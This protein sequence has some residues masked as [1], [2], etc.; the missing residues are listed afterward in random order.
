MS[1][2]APANCRMLEKLYAFDAAYRS[3]NEFGL[4]SVFFR[5][6]DAEESR[7]Y[8]Y[9][10]APL[11]AVVFAETGGDG[12]HFS[13]LKLNGRV[14]EESPVLFTHPP[15]YWDANGVRAANLLQLLTM[16]SYFGFEDFWP[17]K[18]ENK[19]K[20]WWF[21]ESMDDQQRDLLS[22][23]RTHF[24]LLPLDSA[25]IEAMSLGELNRTILSQLQIREGLECPEELREWWYG[26]NDDPPIRS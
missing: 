21:D 11:N 9:E 15:V 4:E 2:N 20:E 6:L 16:Q 26:E 22:A 10:C 17:K 23:L 18:F 19:P 12:N 8:P 3:Q 14:V 24:G 13:L 7:D 25:A 5:L 1:L